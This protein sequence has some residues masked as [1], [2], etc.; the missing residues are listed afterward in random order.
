MT[1]SKR[2]VVRR[3]RAVLAVLAALGVLAVPVA[4]SAAGTTAPPPGP[5]NPVR[6][7]GG[8][9]T[10]T[11]ITGDRVAVSGKPGAAAY[12]VTPGAGRKVSFSIETRAGQTYVLPSDAA[13]LIDAGL[14]DE[15]LFN[16]TR[17][18]EWGYGDARRT[19]IPVLTK[20]GV[21]PG[22]AA[23]GVALKSVGLR[24]AEVPKAQAAT[25]WQRL[26]PAAG[27]TTLAAGVSKL[28][29]DG[30]VF[31]ALDK[32]VPQIGAPQA[33]AKG[34]T[35]KGVTVAVLDTGYDPDHPDLKGVVTQAV[36]FTDAPDTMD[37][38]GH[39]THVASTVAGSGAASGGKYRGVAPDA[40]IAVGKV[41]KGRGGNKTSDVIAGMEWAAFEIKAP[42]VNMS[43]SMTDTPALD[44]LE[45]AVNTLSEQTGSLFVAAAGN[46]GLGGKETLQS[47]G[48]ADAALTVGAVGRDESLAFF[49]S[50]GPRFI[51]R[52]VKPD[53]TAPGVGIV[54]ARA[55]GGTADPYVAEDGTSMAAPHVA[56][57]AAILLQQH[58]GW[59]WRQLKAA[60]M[61]TARPNPALTQYEQGAGRVDVA[62]AV[63]QDVVGDTGN[64]WT[65]RFWPHNDNPLTSDVTYT[66][67]SDRPV[68]LTLTEDSP[69][70]LSADH[71]TLPAGGHATVRL[72]L[73]P[74][75]PAGD[76]PGILTATA[77]QSVLRTLAGAYVEP[78]SY[79]LTVTTVG[80]N[81]EP[82]PDVDARLYNLKTGETASLRFID[83][84]VH[85]RLGPGDWNLKA[86]LTEMEKNDEQ[87]KILSETFTDRP[88][89]VGPADV[90][91]TLDARLGR[92]I[93]LTVDDPAA[94]PVG[95]LRVVVGNTTGTG[96]EYVERFS[97]NYPVFVLPSRREGRTY[98]AYQVLAS[99][100][101][102]GA[103]PSRYDL[104]DYRT[105]EIPFN[106]VRRF[107]RA[108]LAKVA[109]TFRAQDTGGTAKFRREI[110][111][112]GEQFLVGV[113]TDV[114]L[115]GTLDSYLTPGAG[116][117][118]SGRVTQG[119]YVLADLDARAV[120]HG[121]H[122]ETWNTA[123]TG[124]G[125][126][127][128]TRE[129]DELGYF[130]GGL[131]SDGDLGHTGWDGDITGT[132]KLLNGDTVLQ[133]NDLADCDIPDH[134]LLS[135]QVPPAEGAYTV[136]VSARR[137]AGRG[138]STAVDTSWTFTSAHTTEDTRY[139]VPSIRYI[140]QGLDDSNRA[141]PG[142]TTQ[143]PITA[144]RGKLTTLR[145]EASFDDGTTWQD[146]QVSR[147]GEGWT[148]SVTNPATPGHVT[149]RATATG[150]GGVQVNQTITRAYA[151]QN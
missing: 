25:V 102:A 129:G 148:T 52:A 77:G 8:G 23:A 11:L 2:P 7:Q 40:K 138:L 33:W 82:V 112:P 90:R 122:T 114:M 49:S 108:G 100:A 99:D 97:P 85:R 144:D 35:G 95:D 15:R 142:S 79:S 126:L 9:D 121:Q 93:E 60:L 69:Y 104:I 39:G 139:E 117:R 30:G 119:G 27:A 62:R 136:A 73:D 46:K 133:E 34:L 50:R 55:S 88:I 145:V 78:E 64:L 6:G 36:N 107:T 91:L 130:F 48:S 68:E 72:T 127:R 147:N 118:W 22:P 14:V 20:G 74:T 12:E 29:L 101:S 137:E 105:G 116:L 110:V 143:I 135:A 31:P 86:R 132:V 59:S 94:K 75:L 3:R 71:L 141:K 21:A 83:G 111:P 58:P 61:A 5:V 54:A 80:R 87:N 43:L 17:L 51:D 44:P 32:S 146:L 28:W 113:N 128:I 84:V 151:V 89:R 24:A 65:Y 70:T 42:I 76:H 45:E 149:L 38:F 103:A 131:F 106:P 67:T 123:V 109:M 66:N 56:G 37:T 57:A 125:A 4:P 10:I 98:L 81:G 53:I 115:P 26:H 19:T 120:P 13:P 63:T 150:P 1:V 124:P 96:Y 18:L 47:P 92:Q 140:P 16:V 41:L 134:C